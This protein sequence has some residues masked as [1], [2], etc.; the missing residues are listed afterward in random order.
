MLLVGGQAWSNPRWISLDA[1]RCGLMSLD[2]PRYASIRLDIR[3]PGAFPR[4]IAWWAF[5]RPC[6]CRIILR[7]TLS[8][9]FKR[10]KGSPGLPN[11][12]G[13]RSL[14]AGFFSPGPLGLVLQGLHPPTVELSERLDGL[15]G[16]IMLL[17]A[18]K[19]EPD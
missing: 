9:R 19:I 17:L 14:D 16:P 6:F 13:F 15:D 5:P 12:A 18:G 2:T 11:P 4:Q 7:S 1:A 8:E 10:F 3:W